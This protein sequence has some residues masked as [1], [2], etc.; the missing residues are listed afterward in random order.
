MNLGDVDL[1]LLVVLHAVL[2]EQSVTRAA[3]RL[4]VTQ[5]AV[6]NALRRLRTMF[7]DPLFIR[8]G[9]GLV[10][11]RRAL[12]AAPHIL[13]II[14]EL[15]SVV[16][17]TLRFDPATSAREFCIALTDHHEVSDFSRL[18]ELF[19][20]RLP[21]CVLRA[22]TIEHL[23]ATDGLALG[24]IDVAIGPPQVVEPRCLKELIYEDELVYI[25]RRNHPRIRNRI[26]REEFARVLHV[27]VQVG[28]ERGVGR[29]G[30]LQLLAQ[31]KLERQIACSVPRYM[32]AAMADQWSQS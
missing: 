16:G 12:E 10:P 8:R 24:S 27:D 9:P 30:Y 28:G 29:R 22:V 6:S 4:H 3:R 20:A 11:T 31:H 25:A 26:T 1:N 2:E 15:E 23:H 32:A 14:E 13:A 19:A 5:S 18:A 17:A 7:D 21:H